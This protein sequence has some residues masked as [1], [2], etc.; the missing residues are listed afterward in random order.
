MQVFWQPQVPKGGA[1]SSLWMTDVQIQCDDRSESRGVLAQMGDE[2]ST[3]L[4]DGVLLT[5]RFLMPCS[6][7]PSSMSRHRACAHCCSSL[8][9]PTLRCIARIARVHCSCALHVGRKCAI[10]AMVALCMAAA[11]VTSAIAM[12][13]CVKTGL[14]RAGRQSL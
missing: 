1:T 5:T 13:V 9:L 11:V 10:V 4:M 14:S 6:C 2:G 7:S 8:T 12:R 3:V